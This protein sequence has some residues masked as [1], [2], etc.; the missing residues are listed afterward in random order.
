M[1]GFGGYGN[2]QAI[3]DMYKVMAH[4]SYMNYPL[5]FKGA[6]VLRTLLAPHALSTHRMTNDVDADWI[7]LEITN[8][9]LHKLVSYS[10]HM[11][12]GPMYKVVQTR[13]HSVGKS[14]GFQVQDTSTGLQY[15]SLDIGIK[16]AHNFHDRY[17]INGGSFHG[18][19]L[20]KIVADKISAVSTNTVLRRV[21]DVYDLYLLSQMTGITVDGVNEVI[22]KTRLPVGDFKVFTTHIEGKQGLRHAYDRMQGVVNKPSFDEVHYWATKLCEPYTN[23]AYRA[24]KNG[25]WVPPTMETCGWFDMSN[26]PY[27][28]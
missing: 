8:S 9:E 14:A 20:L 28:Q 21:K 1:F 19:A 4:M 27:F 10:V 16:P 11:V 13:E 23:G 25:F 26:Q 7:G 22:M 18:S 24:Y 6:M 15:F 17:I 12:L 5:L 3:D 2:Q